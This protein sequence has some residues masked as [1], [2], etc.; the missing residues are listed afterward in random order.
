MASLSL[1]QVN[2]WVSD[3]SVKQLHVQGNIKWL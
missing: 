3:L 1:S 2:H